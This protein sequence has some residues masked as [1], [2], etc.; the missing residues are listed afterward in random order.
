MFSNRGDEGVSRPKPRKSLFALL[1]KRAITR[2]LLGGST[3]WFLVGLFAWGLF[4]L[5]RA[6]GTGTA[7]LEQLLDLRPGDR[8]I[9]RPRR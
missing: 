7:T 6:V 3:A 2:G 1:R 8:L 5:R 4:A 9:I